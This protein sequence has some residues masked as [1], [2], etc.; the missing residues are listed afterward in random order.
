MRRVVLEIR[1]NDSFLFSHF[2]KLRFLA[3]WRISDAST[4]IESNLFKP[5][6]H[7]KSVILM[8]NPCK[9]KNFD[10]NAAFKMK[11]LVTL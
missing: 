11:F 4:G 6:I 5:F 7:F 10:K 2:G 9:A 1:Q 3:A 8:K